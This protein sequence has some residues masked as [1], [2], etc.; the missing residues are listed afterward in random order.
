MLGPNESRASKRRRPQ[1]YPVMRHHFS[2]GKNLFFLFR[3]HHHHHLTAFK[4]G[5]LFHRSIFFK[6][7]FN[8]LKQIHAQ[9][10]V[11]QFAPFESNSDFG[12]VAVIQK[13]Y[14]TAQLNLIVTFFSSRSKFDFFD[15]DLFLLLLGCLQFFVLFKLVLAKIHDFANWWIRIRRNLN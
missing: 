4:L 13:F 3:P 2:N 8:T 9:F 6:I 5:K 1:Y 10:A 7:L 11:G 14:K 12:F 15:L